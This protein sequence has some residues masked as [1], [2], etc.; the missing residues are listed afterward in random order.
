[1]YVW[2]HIPQSPRVV[3]FLADGYLSNLT[4]KKCLSQA[5]FQTDQKK[6]M[7]LYMYEDK[8]FYYE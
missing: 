6:I 3:S 7:E 5:R 8:I 1:M 4:I 2:G